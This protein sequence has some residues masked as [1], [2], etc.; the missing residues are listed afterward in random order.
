MTDINTIQDFSSLREKAG[1][2]IAE[3]A[4]LIG[5]SDRTVRRYEARGKTH[6]PPPALV[7]EAMRKVVLTRC[8]V[9]EHSGQSF[10]FVDIFAG[11]GG[12]RIPFN[13]INGQC[14]FT[15]E[16][17]RFSRQTYAAN[18]P[19]GDDHEFAGEWV[20]VVD[21]LPADNFEAM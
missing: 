10:R 1:L 11:I 13:E 15:A 12:L 5:K 4:A 19:D 9:Q 6:T 3:T 8:E 18:F 21:L 14:V 16:W 20:A 2:S 7:L 17:D